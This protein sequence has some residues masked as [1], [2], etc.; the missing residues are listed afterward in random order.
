M[1]VR[2]KP[3]QLNLRKTMRHLYNPRPD[4][5]TVV[6]VPP[7]NFL[8]IDGRG[9]PNTA[10]AYQEAV[11]ALYSLAYGLK[12]HIKRSQQMDFAVMPLEGLWWVKGQEEFDLR[13]LMERRDEWQWTMMIAQPEIVTVEMVDTLRAEAVRKREPTGLN[14]IRFESFAEGHAAQTLHGGPYAAELPTVERLHAFIL[15]NGYTL[16][17]KHHEIYLSDPRRSVPEKLKTI[18]R[19]PIA[20]VATP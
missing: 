17:G 1:P 18:L 7:L 4:R 11:E 8:M 5:V 12:F 16:R 15:A 10:P 20:T 13:E 9:N 6:D 2:E 19:Q 14:L 3:T